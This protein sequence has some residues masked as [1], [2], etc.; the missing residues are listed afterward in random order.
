MKCSV[1]SSL[2]NSEIHQI[3]G[4]IFVI[5]IG[6][7]TQLSIG[8]SRF[9]GSVQTLIRSGMPGRIGPTPRQPL[10][11]RT[12]WRHLASARSGRFTTLSNSIGYVFEE[13][14]QRNIKSLPQ[15]TS[16]S[17]FSKYRGRAGET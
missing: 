7:S 2:L 3:M 15:K 12:L 13:E 6:P 4:R 17:A 8:P 14:T 9:G 5:E 10:I 16:G 1:G 11:D